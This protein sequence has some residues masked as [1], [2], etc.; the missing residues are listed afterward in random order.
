MWR[1]DADLPA[2]TVASKQCAENSL[3]GLLARS[4]LKARA[5]IPVHRPLSRS[6]KARDWLAALRPRS[7]TARAEDRFGDLGKL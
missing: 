5:S 2:P 4:H 1:S 7:V 6:V 3:A